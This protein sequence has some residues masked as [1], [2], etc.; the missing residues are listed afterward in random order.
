[1]LI[2]KFHKELND[3]NSITGDTHRDFIRV[4]NFCDLVKPSK[5]DVL[6][7][8][9]DV[10]I[11]YFGNPG[12]YTL[13][14]RLSKLPITLFCIHGNHE[15]RPE[16]IKTYK[17][18]IKYG[19]TVYWEPE[20]PSLLFAKDGEIYELNGKRCIAIGGAY[21]IDKQYRLQ[22]GKPWWADEQPSEK[23][24]RRVEKRLEAENWCVDVV[25]SHTCPLKCLPREA[26][27][28]SPTSAKLSHI[29]Q[30]TERWLDTI[31]DKLEYRRWYC[32]HFHI[33][34]LKDRMQFLFRDF[35]EL[36]FGVDI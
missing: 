2:I 21:S 17:E 3:T 33:N 14:K 31:K 6:V 18:T 5:D 22:T 34:K 19:G 15:A 32:G 16:S 12:D 9:G 36:D 25:L 7:I 24:K 30:Q 28:F 35:I 26:L 10:G 23:I 4:E 11:N 13:K 1:V 8:L 20:F 29:N 27:I